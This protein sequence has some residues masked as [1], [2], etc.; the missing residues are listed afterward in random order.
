MKKK[1]S[2]LIYGV[3]VLIGVGCIYL[4]CLRAEQ[5][6]KEAKREKI[7]KAILDIMY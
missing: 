2:L 1:K 5:L 7:N 6:D 4:M 3:L